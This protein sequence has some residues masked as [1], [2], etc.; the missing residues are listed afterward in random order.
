MVA[1]FALAAGVAAAVPQPAQQDV[2]AWRGWKKVNA[3]PF[4]SRGH[5]YLWVDVYADPE[6]AAAYEAHTAPAPV[7]LRVVV[8]GRDKKDGDAVGLTAMV[9]MPPGYDPAHGDWWYAALSPDG[10]FAAAQGRLRLCID[11]HRQAPSD[12]LFGVVNGPA[13]PPAPDGADETPAAD[14]PW[15]TARPPSTSP[16]SATSAD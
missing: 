1:L 2:T 14:R 4:E 9:K 8:A 13:A 16:V 12:H 7:G 5:G 15:P 3:A 6:L 11:C 10:R